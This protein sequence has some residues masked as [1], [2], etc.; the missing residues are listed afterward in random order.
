MDMTFPTGT[1]QFHDEPN[2]N[3]QMNR[4][5][6]FGN[7]PVEEVRQAA[8]RIRSLDDWKNEFLALAKQSESQGRIQNAAGY[9][10]AVD[11]FLSQGDPDRAFVYDKVV[12]LFREHFR[13]F[14]E[15][16]III[17]SVVRYCGVNLPVW[18]VDHLNEGASKGTVLL[19]GGFDCYKEEL[20][21][22]MVFFAQKGYDFY[23]F[24][25]PGQGEI[26]RKHKFPMTHEWEKPV[27]AVL[28]YLRL[29]NVTLIGLSLGGYLAPRAALHDSRIKRVVSWGVM[30]DFFDVVISR[31][32][33]FIETILRILIFFKLSPV[34]NLL[35]RMKMKRDSYTQWGVD[36]GMHTFG[37]DSPAEYFRRLRLYSLKKLAHLVRQDVLLMAGNEDHFVPLGHYYE[38]AKKLMNVKSLTGRVFTARE[39]AEN[40]C[41]FGN[42][43]LA[44]E[45]MTDW[46]VFHT[47]EKE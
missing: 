42:L 5:L 17:E 25:G 26:L 30:Y 14:F 33:R 41:Q 11:F 18:Q 2:F 16:K 24:E 29:D 27:K 1:Y 23:Y 35:L 36:H 37:V 45:F 10:R 32:G 19:T 15:K 22:V 44:L 8:S 34:M 38:L 13:K 12:S 40:H 6:V 47:G 9:Y 46:I 3:Y 21:P 20:V 7:L 43:R 28:D 4:W 31:R 39:K